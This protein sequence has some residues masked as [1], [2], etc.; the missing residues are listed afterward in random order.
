MKGGQIGG[1]LKSHCVGRGGA[2]GG[3]LE[4]ILSDQD[5]HQ[6]SAHLVAPLGFF[7]SKPTNSQL[8]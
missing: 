5:G 2:E 1:T 3:E 7:F 8:L 4:R 6:A